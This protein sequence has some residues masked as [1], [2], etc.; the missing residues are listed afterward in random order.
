MPFL[1]LL[2]SLFF[3]LTLRCSC[4]CPRRKNKRRSRVSI[5]LISA[6]IAVAPFAASAQSQLNMTQG[7]S[8]ISQRVYDL[9]MTI[10][11]I[12]CVIGLIVF[13][14]MFA[15]RKSTR[16]NSSHVKI[17][18]AVFCLKKKKQKSANIP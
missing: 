8:E 1:F 4:G 17:S 12:C 7:V 14:I 16:L 11:Y 10:F 9:H 2:T 5:R 18:Y 3:R 6:L 15:D 13:G